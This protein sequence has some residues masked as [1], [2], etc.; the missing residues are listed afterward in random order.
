LNAED[1]EHLFTDEVLAAM[2]RHDW[3]GNV[4]ELRNYVERSV[5]LDAAAPGLHSQRGP[6]SLLPSQLATG[7]PLPL[8]R[9]NVQKPFKE[10]KEEV[11][12]G[13]E[14]QYLIALLAASGGNI[15]RA[16]RLAKM[17]RMYLYRLLQRYEL[18]GASI[19]D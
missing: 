18:R 10:A 7:T 14:R 2:A 3:P 11:I 5:V 16:A 9:A 13:F 6:E 19:K 17:D 8:G 4:R 1:C 15:S 12:A